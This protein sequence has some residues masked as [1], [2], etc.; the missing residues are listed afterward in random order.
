MGPPLMDDRWIYGSDPANIF[1]TIVQ[2]RPNGMPT[3]GSKIPRYQIWQLTS[4]VRSMS[5]L[6]PMDVAPNR[7]DTM[8]AREPE[9]MTA[10]E[11]AKP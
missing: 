4:Y 6:V 7:G 10:P 9:A 11:P 5:G 3:F 8:H 2:G 1:A